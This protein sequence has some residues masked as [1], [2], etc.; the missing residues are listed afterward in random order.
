MSVER[1]AIPEHLLLTSNIKQ[2]H[3]LSATTTFGEDEVRQGIV[4]ES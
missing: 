4:D 2:A 1:E 3:Y